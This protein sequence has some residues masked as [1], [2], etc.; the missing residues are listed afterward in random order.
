MTLDSFGARGTLAVGDEK[1]PD[2][3][4][5]RAGGHMADIAR[6]PYSIK[7]LLENLVRHEDSRDVSRRAHRRAGSRGHLTRRRPSWRFTP[8]RVLLQDFTGVPAVV[9]LAALRDALAD[10]GGDPTLVNPKV[11]VELVIDH[12][13][14][15]EV[16][17]TPRRLRSQRGDR[18][19]PQLG[20]ATSCCAGPNR[21]SSAS[22]SS[23]QTRGS[24]TR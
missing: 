11:P 24:A 19:R 12:S 16:S 9:D 4:A 15:A 5:G 14:I 2:L 3:A 22:P 18:A 13:V 1:L 10:L 8:E 7:I 6:L 20:S 17:G 23:P 21:P